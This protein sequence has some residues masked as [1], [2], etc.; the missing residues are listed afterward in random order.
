MDLELTSDLLDLHETAHAVLD[1]HAPLAVSR[2]ALEGGADVGPLWH[3]LGEL[4]WYGIGLDADDPFGV[5]GVCLLAQEIGAHAAPTVFTD[6]AVLGQVAAA[7]SAPWSGRI[8]S[9]EVGVT[10]ALA[11]P[12]QGWELERVAATGR[13]D[14]DGL[15]VDGVKVGVHHAER[16]DRIAV[17][18]RIDGELAVALVDRTADGVSVEPSDGL[19]AAS[20]PARVTLRDVRVAAEDVLRG[21]ELEPALRRAIDVGTVA[22][23]AEGLGAAGAALDLASQ[24]AHDRE[25]FGTPIG[26]FQAIKHILAE[27]HARRE[28]AWASV[29]YAAAALDE[30]LDSART[31]VSVAKA[32]ASDAIR[33]IAEGALQVLGGI[34]VTW[35]HD[36][37]LL[38]RRVLD[39]EQRFG[40]AA[41]HEARL[42]EQLLAP[43]RELASASA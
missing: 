15:V 43:S 26:T 20:A 10:L 32:H 31:D 35:E 14:G 5:V 18:L 21:P 42:Q 13:V 4:G 25:Q 40:A 27:Q 29:Y 3:Q 33:A 2:A 9:G 41:G 38:F 37:H 12:G 1:R 39:R 30:G 6:T 8:E 7:T 23:A 36:F 24:Y 17:V 11:E 22:A 16:I 19:D 28:T 34:G